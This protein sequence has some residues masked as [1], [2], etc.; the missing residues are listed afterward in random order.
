MV[1]PSFWISLS[2][3][4]SYLVFPLWVSLYDWPSSEAEET[5]YQYSSY[6]SI[7][8]SR[9][10]SFLS[11]YRR[12]LYRGMAGDLGIINIEQAR[13][14]GL[15]VSSGISFRR[16]H[17]WADVMAS[18]QSRRRTPISF[19][20]RVHTGWHEST[21]I[22]ST[23]PASPSCPRVP[24]SCRRARGAYLRLTST[25]SWWCSPLRRKSREEVVKPRL[26]SSHGFLGVRHLHDQHESCDQEGCHEDFLW[27]KRCLES[28]EDASKDDKQGKEVP[29]FFQDCS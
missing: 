18:S 22:R 20:G 13:R 9:W 15:R 6:C 25:S 29:E 23:S 24:R 5:D 14:A 7:H 17:E 16:I 11:L 26:S 1:L 21:W 3:H 8:L 4:R 19:V 12:S 28:E 10:I 2:S 27:P